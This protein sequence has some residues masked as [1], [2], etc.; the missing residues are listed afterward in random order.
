M[1]TFSN[2]KQ[3]EKI[4]ILEAFSEYLKSVWSVEGASK[5]P[6]DKILANWLRVQL[7]QPVVF[8]NPVIHV[9]H[10]EIEWISKTEAG[11]DLHCFVAKSSTGA[12]LLKTL[13]GY[14]QS[15]EQ[16][17]LARWLHTLKASDFQDE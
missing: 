15:Y 12:V 1:I 5:N 14:C 2:G 17:Q 8:H 4:L 3:K 13:L 9:L 16:W 11:S 10:R 6:S 7:Q